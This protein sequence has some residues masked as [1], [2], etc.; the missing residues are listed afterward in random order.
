MSYD[1]IMPPED[2]THHGE[3]ILTPDVPAAPD[4]VMPP[5]GP[6]D[7]VTSPP[8][9]MVMLENATTPFIPST[10]LPTGANPI[11][12]LNESSSSSTPAFPPD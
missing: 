11:A 3:T 6:T 2:A 5:D 1:P 7:P 8:E 9:S 4:V 12:P 10:G